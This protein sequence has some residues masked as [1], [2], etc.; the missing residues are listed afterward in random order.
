M[1]LTQHFVPILISNC[2]LIW[3]DGLQDFK[4]TFDAMR[5]EF[6]SFCGGVNETSQNYLGCS[7]RYITLLHLLERSGFLSKG[8][9]VIIEWVENVI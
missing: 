6:N 3:G 4:K 9:I 7:S 1:K 5:Q 8:H 2:L